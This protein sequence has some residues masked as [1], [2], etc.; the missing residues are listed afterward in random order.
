VAVLSGGIDIHLAAFHDEV[1]ALKLC[2]VFQR[3][4]VDRDEIGMLAG[5]KRPD[6]VT[7]LEMLRR[8]D[9]GRADGGLGREAGLHHQRQFPCIAAM[10]R[11]AGIGAEGDAYTTLMRPGEH[12]QHPRANLGGLVTRG[13][14]QPVLVG[15]AGNGHT[16]Q[17]G[18]YQ[19]GIILPEQTDRLVIEIGAMLDGVNARA[20]GGVDPVL[21]MRMGRDIAAHAFGGLDDG[22]ELGLRELLPQPRACWTAHPPWR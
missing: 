13:G 7:H 12:V 20:Q 16:R 22:F 18:R 21:A 1:D 6:R 9:R 5:L 4:A 3:I 17:H 8:G 15:P 19:H 14:R 2:H 11:D 10:T